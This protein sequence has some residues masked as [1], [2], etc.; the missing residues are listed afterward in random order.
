M[1]RVRGRVL[2]YRKYSNSNRIFS[3][4]YLPMKT[5]IKLVD[6]RTKVDL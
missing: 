2:K 6:I 1:V 3:A 4:N 5:L